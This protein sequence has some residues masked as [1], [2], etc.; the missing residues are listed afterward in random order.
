M[1]NNTRISYEPEADV[2]RMEIADKPIEFAREIGNLVV[3]FSKEGIPVYVEVLEATKFRKATDEAFAK[4]AIAV[5]L[6]A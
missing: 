6:G 2:L 5:S 1:K 3:H 4:P